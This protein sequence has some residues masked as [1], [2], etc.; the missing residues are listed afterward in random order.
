MVSDEHN[1]VSIFLMVLLRLWA[2]EHQAGVVRGDP[3]N[4]KT[5]PDLPG[6]SPD[7]LFLANAHRERLRHNFLDGPCDLAVE[8]VS[9]DYRQRDIVEKFAEYAQGGVPEYWIVD[10]EV[11]QARFFA[12]G[13]T[14][15]R[16]NLVGSD[17]IFRSPSC[18]GCGWIKLLSPA[19]SVFPQPATLL[20][21]WNL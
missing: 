20:R 5:G 9:P 12:L 19:A 16:G 17:H 21:A 14:M 8:V 13:G 7:V 3:F 4:M 11:E 15:L 2:E 18:R 1:D 6:R 10:Y